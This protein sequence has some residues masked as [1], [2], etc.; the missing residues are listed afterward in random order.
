MAEIKYHLYCHNK[1]L[2]VLNDSEEEEEDK[3]GAARR[4]RVMR[5]ARLAA[6]AASRQPVRPI[7]SYGK[8]AVFAKQMQLT[9]N[10]CG[11]L[12]ATG[13]WLYLPSKLTAYKLVAMRPHPSGS[14]EYISIYDGHTKYQIGAPISDSGLGLFV[15]QTK[16]EALS[17]ILPPSS[18]LTGMPLAL[19]KVVVSGRGYKQGSVLSFPAMTPIRVVQL[20]P[21]A[22]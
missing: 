13:Q 7:S 5:A 16:Q 10:L 17:S 6:D 14:V 4:A 2:G 8:V 22:W 9:G 11:P 1:Q 18:V 3:Y 21:R 19:L 12:V 15:Y 20:V